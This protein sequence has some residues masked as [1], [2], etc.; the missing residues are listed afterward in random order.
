MIT[1]KEKI[2]KLLKE[3]IGT[4]YVFDDTKG[5]NVFQLRGYGRG[6]IIICDSAVKE[7][8]YTRII[9]PKLTMFSVDLE[10]DQPNFNDFFVASVKMMIEMRKK[11]EPN[12]S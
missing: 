7:I 12:A 1:M 2:E 11:V 6:I 8:L 5:L 3:K 4:D 10:Q 9:Y